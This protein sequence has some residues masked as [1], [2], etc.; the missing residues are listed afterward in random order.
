MGTR[1]VY[2]QKLRNGDLYHDPTINPG[3]GSPRCPR[4]L[5]L[6]NPQAG[7]GEWTITPV[8]HDTTAVAGS[9]LGALLSAVHSF[10]TGIPFI[11]NRVRGPKWLPFVVGLPPLLLYSGASAA[12]GAYALPKFA[13][14][15]V[16][17]YYAAS[18]ASHYWISLLTRKIEEG[19]ISQ[20]QK[21]K[22]K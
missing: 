21:G 19:H 9:G 17:S 11:Q 22:V 14:L 6:L 10:N 15:T 5:S 1:E 4:C 12:F 20:T 18:S 16:T 2:E 7:N 8:L 3:L 13:Q